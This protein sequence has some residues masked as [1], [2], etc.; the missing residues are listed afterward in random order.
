MNLSRDR[1]DML[2]LECEMS[3]L[4]PVFEHLVPVGSAIL[5]G[6]ETFRK[7]NPSRGSRSQSKP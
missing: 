5:E 2:W 6:C 3:S 1:G 7:Y 4:A